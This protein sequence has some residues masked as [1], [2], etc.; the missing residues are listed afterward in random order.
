ITEAFRRREG[1]GTYGRFYEYEELVGDRRRLFPHVM[2]GLMTTALQMSIPHGIRH[3][4]A[5]MEPSLCRLLARFGIHFET[6]GPAVQY[7]GL[8]QPC[9]SKLADLLARIRVERPEIWEVIT[10]SGGLSHL[11]RSGSRS[12]FQSSPGA[13]DEPHVN[14]PEVNR[15]CCREARPAEMRSNF[16]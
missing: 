15:H 13:P 10:D 2:L 5:V 6:L 9:Y 4:C 1:D 7:H 14:A 11:S 16:N 8:R 3:V 12:Q